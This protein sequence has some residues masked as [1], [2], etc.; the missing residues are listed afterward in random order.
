MVLISYL[1]M[2]RQIK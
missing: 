2:E 1:I